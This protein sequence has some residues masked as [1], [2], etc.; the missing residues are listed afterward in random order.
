MAAKTKF[1]QLKEMAN[2]PE[3]KFVPYP[4][5]GGGDNPVTPKSADE[6]EAPG[7]QAAGDPDD[8]SDTGAT[9]DM[10]EQMIDDAKW[11]DLPP[12]AVTEL[13]QRVL[14]LKKEYRDTVRGAKQPDSPPAGDV[15]APAKE[16]FDVSSTTDGP[17][18]GRKGGGD[19]ETDMPTPR[20][21][22]LSDD[23]QGYDN[24][25]VNPPDFPGVSFHAP[26]A[27]WQPPMHPM[28]SPYY[29]NPERLKRRGGH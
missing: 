7:E 19:V 16:Q 22:H 14:N 23:G 21:P 29:D 25:R 1:E 27:A 6:P 18:L 2:G 20:G 4:G 28:Y 12:E 5:E 11:D 15:G 8:K 17:T 9:L 3:D 10:L 26:M 13:K 24:A